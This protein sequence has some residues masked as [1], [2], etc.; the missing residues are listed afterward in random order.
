MKKILAAAL[1]FAMLF[2]CG[3]GS[4]FS[5]EYYDSYPFVEAGDDHDGTEQEIRNYASL[6]SAILDLVKTRTEQASFRFGS[7]SGS[8]IDDLAA[9]CVEIKNREPLGAYAVKSI[10]YDTSR[11]ISYYTADISISYSRS[12]EEIAAVRS[13]S[14][15]GE[16]GSHV[17]RLME[18]YDGTT[19]V[20]VYSSVINEDYIAGLIEEYYYADPLLSVLE[21]KV[22]IMAYPDSGAERIYRLS[23]D[24]GTD[25]ES[26]LAM[27]KELSLRVE[28][29]ASSLG[30]G[31]SLL[32]ALECAEKLS[33]M[34]AME[35]EACLYPGT[36]YGA[37]VEG[38]GDCLA[39]AMAYKALCDRLGLDCL[40]VRGEYNGEGDHAWN[41]I[42]IDGEYYHADISRFGQRA[43]LLSDEDIWGEYY[44]SRDSYPRCEGSLGPEDVFEPVQ[45]DVMEQQPDVQ[46][47][48]TPVPS[49]TPTPSPS[50]EP[51]PEPEPETSP[52][53]EQPVDG[54]EN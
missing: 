11:I 31:E 40:V 22:E 29:L 9:V 50:P 38:S 47:T 25:R 36:A 35:E 23:L 15:L 49:P 53:P 45:E 30:I 51:T 7:Y 27:D 3:C 46:P 54:K 18:S 13:V 12:A 10:S 17:R 26:L 6:K 20:R 39:L 4:V 32:L 34:A 48:P 37:L 14:G 42:A 19:V 43:F 8:L 2:A 16:F 33:E 21:P 41:I 5:A 52:E 44:W 1:C 24:Y 28:E